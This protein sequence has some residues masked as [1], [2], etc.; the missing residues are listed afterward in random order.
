MLTS[1]ELTEPMRKE[2]SRL[3]NEMAKNTAGLKDFSR[4]GDEQEEEED[5]KLEEEE[6]NEEANFE[7]SPAPLDLSSSQSIESSSQKPQQGSFHE[8]EK[9]P[10]SDLQKSNV[11]S[12]PTIQQMSPA[13]ISTTSLTPAPHAAPESSRVIANKKTLP[14]KKELEEEPI[15][16]DD[17][18]NINTKKAAQEKI[19][20]KKD[21][22]QHHS[23]SDHN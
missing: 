4:I 14:K 1:D 9:T 6:N 16:K 5:L 12:Q 2:M 8:H 13:Q 21:N 19:Q 23:K 7:T 20:K 10:K 3:I 15:Q 18:K 17:D 11:H 22:D